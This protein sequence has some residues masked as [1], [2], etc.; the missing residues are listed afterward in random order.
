MDIENWIRQPTTIHGFAVAAAGVG[1]ALTHLATGNTTWDAVIGAAAY[2][3]VHLGIDDHSAFEQ[4]VTK[5]TDDAIA[6]R[7][8][9]TL[10]GDAVGVATTAPASPTPP[11]AA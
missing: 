7:G 5:L 2:V 3:L 8:P 9:Q 6:K 1:A 11:A 4:S 10:I